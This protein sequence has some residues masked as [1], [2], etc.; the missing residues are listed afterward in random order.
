MSTNQVA[1]SSN[2]G[3]QR[4][5]SGASSTSNRRLCAKFGRNRAEVGRFR[6]DR[7]QAKLGRDGR[8]RARSAGVGRCCPRFGHIGPEF[9]RSRPHFGHIRPESANVD[10]LCSELAPATCRTMLFTGLSSRRRVLARISAIENLVA[11]AP[12]REDAYAAPWGIL[13]PPPAGNSGRSQCPLG[14]HHVIMS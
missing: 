10:Q 7:I 3:R 1:S 2:F 14:G 13:R 9:D 12:R 11:P 4:P 6:V 8:V 5:T